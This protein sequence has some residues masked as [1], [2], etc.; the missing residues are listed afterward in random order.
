ME[1]EQ[2]KPWKR[3]S[4]NKVRLMMS[5]FA[6][7][8]LNEDLYSFNLLDSGKVFMDSRA[9][10]EKSRQGKHQAY[11]LG[12]MINRIVRNFAKE[13]ESSID[14]RLEKREKELTKA[15]RGT[16]GLTEEA[17]KAV[18]EKLLEAYKEELVAKKEALM[19]R[20][21]SRWLRERRPSLT[22]DSAN[23]RFLNSGD[24]SQCKEYRYYNKRGDYIRA[25]CEEYA[26]LP[27]G[28][29]ESL[30]LSDRFETIE[31]AVREKRRL[32][33]T[34]EADNSTEASE[35]RHVMIPYGVVDRY[36]IGYTRKEEKPDAKPY[37]CPFRLGALKSVELCES[38]E[39]PYELTDWQKREIEDAVEERGAPYCRSKDGESGDRLRKIRM[40]LTKKG[41]KIYTRASSGWRPRLDD[42]QDIA[43]ARRGI[44][45]FIC[46][47]SRAEFYFARFGKE[48]EV[49]EVLELSGEKNAECTEKMRSYFLE[50][51]S[52]AAYAYGWRGEEREGEAL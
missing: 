7:Q 42:E 34:P 39:K 38:D 4:C 27:V 31:R 30:F 23:A 37:I 43:D 36:L 46:N 6:L 50:F 3:A 47:I 12:N 16:A 21:K 48:A 49:L 52:E 44:Y 22:L 14:A 35:R 19:A 51:H 32:I 18:T 33:L 2:G 29:R 28:K 40:R 15:L 1:M 26:G 24:A 10:G 20:K 9:D 25:L 8:V 5:E 17:L 45:T 41:L 13:A 11:Y